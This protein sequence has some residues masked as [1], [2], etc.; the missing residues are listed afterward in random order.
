[1]FF[2]FRRFPWVV[3]DLLLSDHSKQDYN[4]NSN[5]QLQQLSGADDSL[6]LVD[7]LVCQCGPEESLLNLLRGH[8]EGKL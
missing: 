1:M 2:M 4:P 8:C 7:K 5:G 3:A 6:P